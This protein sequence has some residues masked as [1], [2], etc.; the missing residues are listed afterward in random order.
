MCL[1][2]QVGVPD[3][4]NTLDNSQPKEQEWQ[5]E[6][7]EGEGES[8]WGEM[9]K[10]NAKGGIISENFQ[11]YTSFRRDV[12]FGPED[13]AQ[14]LL[15]PEPQVKYPQ[16]PSCPAGL[17][18]IVLSGLFLNTRICHPCTS[19]EALIFQKRAVCHRK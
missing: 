19:G 14:A 16:Q 9:G 10:C 11:I 17:L 12:W 15:L 1:P 6:K 7:E 13:T 2:G 4:S 5:R 3:N 8:K 18:L